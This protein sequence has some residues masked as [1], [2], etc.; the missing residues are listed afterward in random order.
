MGGGGHGDE[1]RAVAARPI[2]ARRAAPGSAR[3]ARRARGSPAPREA[4][5]PPTDRAIK[6]RRL[7]ASRPAGAAAGPPEPSLPVHGSRYG[8]PAAP[9]APALLDRAGGAR[10]RPL[11]SDRR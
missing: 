8:R 11:A 2:V 10:P 7:S 9:R 1:A 5:T 3:R 6:S 4:Q